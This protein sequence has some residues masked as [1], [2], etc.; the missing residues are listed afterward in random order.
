MNRYPHY[1]Y[2][3]R[4]NPWTIRHQIIF[5]EYSR[6]SI[7]VFISVV[8]M[9][10]ILSDLLLYHKIALWISSFYDKNY[11]SLYNQCMLNFFN[12]NTLLKYWIWSKATIIIFYFRTWKSPS[13]RKVAKKITAKS[14]LLIQKLLISLK[15]HQRLPKSSALLTNLPTENRTQQIPNI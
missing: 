7:S 13:G 9:T 10:L 15:K 14:T 5:Q 1:P 4:R 6:A 12:A 3:F 8:V 2:E 11:D